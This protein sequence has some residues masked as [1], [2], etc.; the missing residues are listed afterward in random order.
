MNR[1]LVTVLPCS[2]F[3]IDCN[4]FLSVVHFLPQDLVTQSSKAEVPGICRLPAVG[5]VYTCSGRCKLN[6]KLGSNAHLLET[7]HVGKYKI[8]HS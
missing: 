3:R 5:I 7:C 6:R 8:I 2:L 4:A 1:A